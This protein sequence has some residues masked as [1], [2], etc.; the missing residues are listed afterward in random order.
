MALDIGDDNYMLIAS[1]QIYEARRNKDVIDERRERE[2]NLALQLPSLESISL[3]AIGGPDIQRDLRVLRQLAMRYQPISLQFDFN[4]GAGFDL[5]NVL[6]NKNYGMSTL[7]L[8]VSDE[9]SLPLRLTDLSH[10]RHLD[11]NVDEDFHTGVIDVRDLVSVIQSN[12]VVIISHNFENPSFIGRSFVS[13]NQL[14]DVM[15]AEEALFNRA[16]SEFIIVDLV[17]QVNLGNDEPDFLHQNL[18]EKGYTHDADSRTSSI[19][20]QI[21]DGIF[22]EEDFQQIRISTAIL[23][24]V[25][26]EVRHPDQWFPDQPNPLGNP[27]TNPSPRSRR[28]G[29]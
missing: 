21:G 8:F 26:I 9:N 17:L 22:G 18:T 10:D 28:V 1:T 19:T 13:D 2:L 16:Q 11:V 25:T 15:L 4:V 12:V 7:D 14:D 23:T 6:Y 5:E 3:T 20:F 24:H 29:A 27:V